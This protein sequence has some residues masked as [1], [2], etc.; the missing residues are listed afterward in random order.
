MT[1]TD[2]QVFRVTA[3]SFEGRVSLEHDFTIAAKDEDEAREAVSNRWPE[4]FRVKVE[5][6]P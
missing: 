4:L 5:P 6:T 1:A 3:R 2:Q